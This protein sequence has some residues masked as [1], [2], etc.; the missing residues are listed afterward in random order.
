MR[1]P[2]HLGFFSPASTA[3][4]SL[5][6]AGATGQVAKSVNEHGRLAARLRIAGEV[7]KAL[8]HAHRLNVVHQDVKPGNFLLAHASPDG[9]QVLFSDFGVARAAGGPDN[10]S[11]N[12]TPTVNGGAR[13]DLGRGVS[14]RDRTNPARYEF[15]AAAAASLTQQPGREAAQDIVRRD[16]ADHWYPPRRQYPPAIHPQPNGFELGRSFGGSK[17]VTPPPRNPG[18]SGRSSSLGQSSPSYSS[19]PLRSG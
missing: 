17:G 7:A 18:R 9:E 19:L 6:S 14:Q 16:R 2:G 4:A 10:T 12:S 13:D 1:R 5:F 3:T 11:D 8:D 15:A